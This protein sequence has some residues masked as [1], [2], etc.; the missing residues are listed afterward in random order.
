MTGR[1]LRGL[2]LDPFALFDMNSERMAHDPVY[3]ASDEM[4]A[5]IKQLVRPVIIENFTFRDIYKQLTTPFKEVTDFERVGLDRENDLWVDGEGFHTPIQG[6]LRIKGYPQP[7]VGKGLI[8]SHDHEGE[9]QSATISEQWV[10]DNIK[11]GILNLEISLTTTG[12]VLSGTGEH[13]F[14]T[15]E[16]EIEQG[17]WDTEEDVL[18]AVSEVARGGK[19]VH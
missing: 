10:I 4:V 14:E 13:V 16:R 7:L 1:T 2:L 11:I 5:M 17:I 3:M 18:K 19:T 6:G 8:L 9:S 12:A 15:W